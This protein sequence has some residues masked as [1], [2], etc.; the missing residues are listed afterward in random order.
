[1]IK[2]SVYPD[3]TEITSKQGGITARVEICR[4][5]PVWSEL[6]PYGFYAILLTLPSMFIYCQCKCIT[7]NTNLLP[8]KL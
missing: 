1:M 4:P 8:Q 5:T 2:V 6:L 3:Q 7:A